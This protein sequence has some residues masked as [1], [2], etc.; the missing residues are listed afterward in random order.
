MVTLLRARPTLLPSLTSL[1]GASTMAGTSP[2][3]GSSLNTHGA[4]ST[5]MSTPYAASSHRYKLLNP[6]PAM[7]ELWGAFAAHVVHCTDAAAR[8]AVGDASPAGAPGPSDDPLSK[9][10]GA[11]EKAQLDA[12]CSQSIDGPNGRKRALAGAFAPELKRTRVAA[13]SAYDAVASS[14]LVRSVRLTD[15]HAPMVVTP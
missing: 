8:A 2:V 9:D 13:R 7:A 11:F 10:W 14:A 6:A 5:V 15:A 4:S 3:C 1:I 12:L